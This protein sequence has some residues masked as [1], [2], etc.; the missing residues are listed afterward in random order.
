LYWVWTL[1]NSTVFLKTPSAFSRVTVFCQSSKV[2]VTRTS[3]A[4]CSLVGG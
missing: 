4:A 1:G 3:F 2:P